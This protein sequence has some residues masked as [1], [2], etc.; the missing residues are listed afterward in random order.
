MKISIIRTV[1]IFLFKKTNEY[2]YIACDPPCENG[3]VCKP[4]NVCQC[5]KNG[6]SGTL[7]NVPDCSNF[8]QQCRAGTCVAPGQCNCTGTGYEGDDC[9]IPVC[10]PPCANNGTCTGPNTCKCSGT[11]YEGKLCT[12][13][14]SN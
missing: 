6:W 8:P 11:G 14:K 3:G 4:G 9:S 1:S 5:L 12:E 7:C 2:L 10:D 13:R